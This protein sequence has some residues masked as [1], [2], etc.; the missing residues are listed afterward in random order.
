MPS[1]SGRHFSGMRRTWAGLAAYPGK[2][3][4][5]LGTV[6]ADGPEEGR[7]EL[8]ALWARLSPHPAPEITEVIPGSVVFV[9][10]DDA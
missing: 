7:R 4:F 9:A 8:T 3:S 5:Y 2:A 1:M 6:L 10:E